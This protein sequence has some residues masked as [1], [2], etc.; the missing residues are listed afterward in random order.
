MVASNGLMAGTSRAVSRMESCMAMVTTSGKMEGN[1]R[2]NTDSTRST[3]VAHTPT[4][5]EAVIEESGL[6]VCSMVLGLSSM[7]RV[8]TR[9][10]V[11]GQPVNSNNGSKRPKNLQ[12]KTRNSFN[13]FDFSE[14]EKSFIP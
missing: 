6:M 14:E 10:K 8:H 4:L 9:R 1:M 5:M 3:A 11:F 2:V 7:Q 13:N 12:H